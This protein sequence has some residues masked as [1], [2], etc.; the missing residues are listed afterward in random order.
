MRTGGTLL[1]PGGRWK[2]NRVGPAATQRAGKRAESRTS[3][4][5]QITARATWE[6]EVDAASTP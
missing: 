4:S 5:P 3:D 6:R 2:L 1:P